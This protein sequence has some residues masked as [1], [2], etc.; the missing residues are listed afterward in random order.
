MNNVQF[1]YNWSMEL[2]IN[3]ASDYWKTL[4]F[5]F[6]TLNYN[7]NFIMFVISSIRKFSSAP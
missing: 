1:N 7:F 3:V 4:N 5:I 6:R 2:L